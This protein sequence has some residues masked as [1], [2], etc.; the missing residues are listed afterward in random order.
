MAGAE[1]API[2]QPQRL[3]ADEALKTRRSVRAFLPTMVPRNTVE[4][5]LTLASRSASGSNI[6]PW[7]VHVISGEPRGPRHGA[8]PGGLIHRRD[9]ASNPPMPTK[10]APAMR[11]N[12]RPLRPSQGAMRCAALATTTS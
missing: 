8:P 5:V 2:M 3:S 10:V 4:E 6:Q 12:Q 11:L 1:Q 7:K 9:I